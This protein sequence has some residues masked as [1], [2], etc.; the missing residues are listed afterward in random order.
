[1]IGVNSNNLATFRLVTCRNYADDVAELSNPRK[2]PIPVDFQI[3]INK[4]T[5]IINNLKKE[6]DIASESLPLDYKIHAEL[7][8]M[9]KEYSVDSAEAVVSNIVSTGKSTGHKA[10]EYSQ[11]HKR[12]STTTR[13]LVVSK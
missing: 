8:R 9:G 12:K 2:S 5:M 10:S 11:K 4:T 1:M 3:K 7:V 6:K 13:A